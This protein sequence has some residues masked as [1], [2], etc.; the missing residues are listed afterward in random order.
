MAMSYRL[1]VIAVG[2]YGPVRQATKNR[3]EAVGLTKFCF[4]LISATTAAVSAAI[5]AT[6]VE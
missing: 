2:R 3:L 5:A 6:E 4:V 1:F